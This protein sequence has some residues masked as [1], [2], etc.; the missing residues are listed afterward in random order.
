MQR[1]LW[2]RLEGA[3]WVNGLAD[4][5]R[6]GAKWRQLRL[7]REAGVRDLE[8]VSI[9]LDPIHDTPGILREYAAVRG[10]D[11]S[12]FSFLT[13]PEGAIRDLLTQFGVITQ[14]QGDILQHTLATMLIDPQG[15]IAHRT[16]G[17][18]WEPQDFVKRMKAP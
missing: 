17:S 16:D 8:L 3:R 15:R 10:I 18:Q 4:V 2:E 5:E 1:A 13:G 12:N 9:T 11:T 14:L 7:A 6:A